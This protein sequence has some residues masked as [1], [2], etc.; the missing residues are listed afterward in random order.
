MQTIVGVLRGGPSREHEV[1]LK[2]GATLIKSLEPERYE[3]RDIYID[4]QG[5]WHVRGRP[6]TPDRALRQ[7]DVALVGL[8]GEFGEDGG[9]QKVLE[10][11][12]VPYAGSNPFASHLAMHKVMSKMHARETGLLTPEFEFVQQPDDSERA[13]REAMR[14]FLQPVV[15]KPVG[16]GSSI[17]ISLVSGYKKIAEKIRGLFSS[18]SSGVVV[19]EYIR[20]REATVGV[21]ESLRGEKLYALPT[22]EII[23]PDRA[24]FFSEDVKYDGTTKEICPGGFSRMVTEELRRAARLAHRA[25]GL[26]HYS[27][28]DFIVTPRGVYYLE[29]NSLPGLSGESLFPKSL[30]AVGIPMEEF[31]SHLVNLALSR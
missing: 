10:R 4:Q 3:V 6:V 17:G 2:S 9:V 30:V 20:G 14:R 18:G 7:I 1:S 27:R 19:E 23:P 8:H 22:V 21:V 29:T 11:H 16:W 5:Q 25:L 31:T 26:R 28:S 24:E 12:G 13:A 15:V